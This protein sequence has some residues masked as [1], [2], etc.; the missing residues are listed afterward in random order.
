M[1]KH[2]VVKEITSNS[3]SFYSAIFSLGGDVQGASGAKGFIIYR[4]SYMHVLYL[5]II[6]LSLG[7]HLELHIKLEVCHVFHLN[8]L[9]GVCFAVEWR[10][11]L[12]PSGPE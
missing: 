5:Y 2:T 11:T 6:L 7:S 1:R 10:E 4:R 12:G 8:V 3:N 9:D